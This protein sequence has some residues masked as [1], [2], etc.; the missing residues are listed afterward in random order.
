MMILQTTAR[1]R[2]DRNLA[3]KRGLNL[4][5]LNDVIKTL[6]KGKSL[7]AKYRDHELGGNLAGFRECHI[8]SDWL[9]IY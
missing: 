9:L 6:L 7:D 5:R 8:Q 1:F 3:K 2:K 4:T